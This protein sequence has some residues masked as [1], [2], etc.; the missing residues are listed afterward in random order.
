MQQGNSTNNLTYIIPG[1]E[2]VSIV[3]EKLWEHIGNVAY[4]CNHEPI[5]R[6]CLEHMFC[7]SVMCDGN[8]AARMIVGYGV[9]SDVA[10]Q[11]IASVYEDIEYKVS[12]VIGGIDPTH[13]Y[14][15]EVS[16]LGD[17]RLIDLGTSWS[18][19]PS[20]DLLLKEIA[21]G[22]DRGDWYPEKFRRLVGR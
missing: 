12:L 20:E 13:S 9:P 19:E 1:A 5:L 15:F 16:A 21:L 11:I 6:L 2:T 7:G 22:L 8:V 14:H 17:I 10:N 3:T 4:F 18:A